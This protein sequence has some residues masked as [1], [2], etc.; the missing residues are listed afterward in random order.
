[1]WYI[2]HIG[3]TNDSAIKACP[4]D[5]SPT[6]PSPMPKTEIDDFVAR[7]TTGPDG[8]FEPVDVAGKRESWTSCNK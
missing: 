2:Y 5:G 7:S 1:M 8:P 6:N 3:V 4:P